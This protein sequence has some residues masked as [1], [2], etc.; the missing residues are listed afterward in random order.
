[1]HIH[2]VCK[3]S[4]ALIFGFCC[5]CFKIYLFIYLFHV[6]EYTV[7]VFRHIRRK[8]QILLRMV[9]SHHVVAEN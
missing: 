5:C 6:C 9:V 4:F 2:S 3:F 1:M 7:T 8:R